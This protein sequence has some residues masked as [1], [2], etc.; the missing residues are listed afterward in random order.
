MNQNQPKR[1]PKKTYP[2]AFVTWSD[3]S[4]NQ[5]SFLSYPHFDPAVLTYAEA[6]KQP[7]TLGEFIS[8]AALPLEA[9]NFTAPVLYLEGQNDLIFCGFNCTTELL[10]GTPNEKGP[11][12]AAFN[13]SSGV[14]VYIQPNTGHGIN[15]H[16]N[17]SG[18]Y[19][20][21]LDWVGKNVM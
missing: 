5:Y 12:V 19:G 15:L 2:N 11:A 4:A 13:G 17:A 7:F 18:S 16:Y 8:S 9:P 1:F 21:M 20:V 14:E 6:T 3:A 10:A